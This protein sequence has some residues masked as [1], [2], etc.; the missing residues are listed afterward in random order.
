MNEE[1]RRSD[2][3]LRA[4][5][6]YLKTRI[7]EKSN[8]WCVIYVMNFDGDFEKLKKEFNYSIRPITAAVE[9]EKEKPIEYVSEINP[10][11]DASIA[12]SYSGIPLNARDFENLIIAKFK[13]IDEVFIDG[14]NGDNKVKVYTSM[15]QNEEDVCIL[16]KFLHSLENQYVK[17]LLINDNAKTYEKKN[18]R[19]KK[20]E[21]QMALNI[22][23][24]KFE[25]DFN[26][27]IMHIFPSK[28]NKNKI[29]FEEKDESFWFDNIKEMYNGK[30]KKK[31]L[32]LEDEPSNAC[33]LDYGSFQNVNIR[34]GAVLFEKIYVELPISKSIKEFCSD[35][36]V[37]D[38]EL[39]EMCHSG[40]L[41]FI[42][43]QPYYRYDYGF[44]NE[45]YKNNPKAILS[46]R[47]ISSLILMDL[48]NINRN[49]FL[50]DCD[51]S[52][53][54][55]P[56]S[57]VFSEAS[58]LDQKIIYDVFTWPQQA[59][60]KSFETMLF[61]SSK[62][63][64]VFGVNNIFKFEENSE[65]QQ[66]VEF[67]FVIHSEKVHIASALD[68]FYF[69]VFNDE[70]Y[71]NRIVTSM[72]GNI[73]NAYK[74]ST[75]SKMSSYIKARSA[76]YDSISFLPELDLI[77]VNEFFSLS[78]INEF[79]KC[80]LMP[81]NFNSLF[82]YL[83]GL[84]QEERYK[85][86]TRYNALLEQEKKKYK[87]KKMIIDLGVSAAVDTAGIFIPF[88]GFGLKVLDASVEK[89]GIKDAKVI[90]KIRRVLSSIIDSQPNDQQVVSF[91]AKINSVARIKQ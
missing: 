8:G 71:S 90:E 53:L 57:K 74:N 47:A 32:L 85:K 26:N 65:K 39:L 27:P 80:L 81:P 55:I 60:R 48:V 19:I 73:L 16:E 64:A 34:N 28:Y 46:R 69:P 33:Y 1:V 9:I 86:V 52:D 24:K 54:V 20:Q 30:I 12:D 14:H 45:V 91:L 76:Q 29:E 18:D 10:I 89:F 22:K 7:F 13:F 11:S 79:S 84:N 88:L 72:M 4:E 42:M 78:E 68:S 43:T 66:G 35:Q 51:M 31:D 40:R 36:K 2:L 77:D 62:K 37:R 83:N 59:L 50:N 5:Y 82:S 75:T 41:T 49:Y 56:L 58:G 87:N 61:G 17:Y 67:E 44:L 6:P 25:D 23:M 70:A 3:Y 15:I 63:V 38:Y 21:N